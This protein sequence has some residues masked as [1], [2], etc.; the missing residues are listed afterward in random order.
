MANV[1]G[2]TP[3]LPVA[4]GELVV[5]RGS[6]FPFRPGGPTKQALNITKDGCAWESRRPVAERNSIDALAGGKA[7]VTGPC[8]G[9]VDAHVRRPSPAPSDYVLGLVS[10]LGLCHLVAAEGP[11]P[12]SSDPQAR[13]RRWRRWSMRHSLPWWLSTSRTRFRRG[14]KV[15]AGARRLEDHDHADAATVL[16]GWTPEMLV[17]SEETFGR[18][19]R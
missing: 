5:D 16:E 18:L 15:R 8:V 19:C 4:A 12:L 14:W 2:A 13:R 10:P 3:A 7:Q 17:M 1:G 11:D 6:L 9:P